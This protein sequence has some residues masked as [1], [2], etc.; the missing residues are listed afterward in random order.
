MIVCNFKCLCGEQFAITFEL[1]SSPK[2]A[3]LINVHEG[4][5][6]IVWP[7]QFLWS[8]FPEYQNSLTIYPAYT[9][10]YPSCFSIEQGGHPNLCH[11]QDLCSSTVALKHNGSKVVHHNCVSRKACII[12]ARWKS[13]YKMTET[14][15]GQAVFVL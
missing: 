11:R 1:C 12:M 13:F 4:P 14:P 2:L 8:E 7:I 15:V 10:D 5:K 6:H 9:E 3:T